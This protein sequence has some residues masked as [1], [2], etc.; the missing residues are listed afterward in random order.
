[1]LKAM[2]EISLYPDPKIQKGGKQSYN[3]DG[4]KLLGQIKKIEND[5]EAKNETKCFNCNMMGHIAAKCQMPKR[6]KGACFK[7]Y[8]LGHNF[9]DCSVK[10]PKINTTKDT[11]KKKDDVNNIFEKDTSFLQRYFVSNM[12]F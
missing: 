3:K 9:R 12:R 1:M 10:E 8:Q 7:C 2:E 4:T 6:E 5:S 11:G